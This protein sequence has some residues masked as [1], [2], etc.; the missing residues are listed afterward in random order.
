VTLE[1]F[2]RKLSPLTRS[3]G[4]VLAK[5]LPHPNVYTLGGL[6]LAWLTP[7][8]SYFGHHFLAIIIIIISSIIDALD[9]AVARVTGKVT[10]MGEFLDSVSDR[11]S[12]TAYFLA[13]AFAGIN[14]SIVIL[15]LGLSIS[16]SYVRAKGELVGVKMRGVGI[17][18]RGSG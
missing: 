18:E 9:G 10:R 15:S 13:L 8:S 1:K 17:M 11:L 14:S 12:D 6:A 4:E 3:I 2:R 5:L 16:I 7:I